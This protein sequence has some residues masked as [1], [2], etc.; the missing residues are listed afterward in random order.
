MRK[1]EKRR[2]ELVEAA[3]AL[4]FERG[5]EETSVS[6]I[7]DA[8]GCSK[9]SFYHHFDSKAEL[10]MAI[11]R[12]R[13]A[14]G[15]EAFEAGEGQERPAERLN[16]LLHQACPFREGE[17][18][19]LNSL[20]QL[21]RARESA[22]LEQALLEAADELYYSSFLKAVAA[23]DEEGG[24]APDEAASFLL[25]QGFLNGCLIIIRQAVSL[26]LAGRARSVQLLRALRAGME[27]ALYLP[28]G[29]LV[30]TEAEEMAGALESAL[31]QPRPLA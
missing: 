15:F 16:R 12:Q 24:T 29:S 25:W 22:A 14:A 1:G 5:Y 18:R 6:D 28:R 4:F 9:G 8:V 31:G 20:V 11:A 23:L 30:I 13:A 3:A 26:P 7:L 21:M 2:R 17:E 19:F 27:D 10:L